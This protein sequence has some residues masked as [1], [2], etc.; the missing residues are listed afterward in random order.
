M[1]F[2]YTILYVE[3]VA[4]TLAFYERAF[5]VERGLLVDSNDY[6]ELVTGGTK[7]AFC[8]KSML[9]DGGK[10][11]GAADQKQPIFE[12]GF[13]TND[14]EGAYAKALGAGAVSIQA[15]REEPWGQVTSY[16]ADPNGFWVEICSPV[17]PPA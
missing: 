17:T 3:D 7:L 15:P 14:V 11:P 4:G 8:A 12:L 9:R 13:E 1:K 5:G 16:V 2:R 6:A 10:T